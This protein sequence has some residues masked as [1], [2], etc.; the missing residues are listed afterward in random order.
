MKINGEVPTRAWLEAAAVWRFLSLLFQLPTAESYAELQR[1]TDELPH[2]QRDRARELMT[3]PLEAWEAEFYRVLGPSGIPACESSYDENALA[4]RGPLIADIA[5]FYEAFAYHPGQAPAE[6]PDHLSVELGF[7]SYLAVKIAFA[8]YEAQTEEALVARKAYERFLKDHV[9]YWAEPF[10]RTV[11]RANSSL[12]S[13]GA[14][15][16]CA[17]VIT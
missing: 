12:Y 9:G 17:L 2:D 5:G 11:E 7:L 4:G 8:L 6:V 1:L 15:W 14:H 16:L 13:T 3:I 10:R